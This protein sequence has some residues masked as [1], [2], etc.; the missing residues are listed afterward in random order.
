M[1]I[2]EYQLNIEAVKKTSENKNRLPTLSR[3]QIFKGEGGGGNP[4][5]TLPD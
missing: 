5:V 4:P 1:K 3:G 2:I